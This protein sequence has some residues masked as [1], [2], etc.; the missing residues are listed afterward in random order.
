MSCTSERPTT[1][2]WDCGQ[3][4]LDRDMLPLEEEGEVCPKCA[5]ARET[6]GEQ[7]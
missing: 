6:T 1:T 3:D 4:Y 7:S 5:L 2:C